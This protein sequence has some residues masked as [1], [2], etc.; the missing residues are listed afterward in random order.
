MSLSPVPEP[1]TS[2]IVAGAAVELVVA[3]AAEDQIVAAAADQSHRHQ[4]RRR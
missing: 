4:S 2:K 1:P 3:G